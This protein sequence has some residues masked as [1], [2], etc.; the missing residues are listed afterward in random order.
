MYNGRSRS[1]LTSGDT[2]TNDIVPVADRLVTRGVL[3]GVAR[4][5]GVE[6]LAPDHEVTVAIRTGR[7]PLGKPYAC[8]G[9]LAGAASRRADP[10][11][12]RAP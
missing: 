5:R 3:I 12:T 2:R 6:S 8:T 1:V 10:L 11:A 7:R 4:Y 9:H